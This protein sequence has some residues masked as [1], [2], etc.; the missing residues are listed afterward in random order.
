MAIFGC[1]RVKPVPPEPT[2][3]DSALQVPISSLMIPIRYHVDSLEEI[4]NSKIAGTFLKQWI[5]VNENHDSLYLELTKKSKINIRW[6]NNILHYRF[7]LYLEGKFIKHIGKNISLK[8]ETPVA[9]EVVLDMTTALSFANDWSLN[10]TTEL[11]QVTWKK[12]P[13]LKIAF[14]NINLRKRLDKFLQ[15]NT[16]LLTSIVDRE[17]DKVIDTR[18]IL[19]KLWL[20][21]QKPIIL[22]NKTRIVWLKHRAQDLAANLLQ[23]G[24]YLG[25]DVRLQTFVKVGIDSTDMPESNRTLPAYERLNSAEDSIEIFLKASASF[26]TINEIL[27]EA[28]QGKIISS[29]NYSTTIKEVST[30]ATNDGLAVMLTVKGDADGSLY[31]R[32]RPGY[33]TTTQTLTIKDFEFDVDSENA[34]LQSADWLLHEDALKFVEAELKLDLSPLLAALPDVIKNAT[35]KGKSANK[36]ELFLTSLV[37]KPEQLLLTK[38]DFQLILKAKG[39]AVIGLQKEVFAK[40]QQKTR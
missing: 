20:D 35:E 4:I 17:I 34:L 9:L 10:A 19:E 38:N 8:N 14:V 7:P 29:N 25:L 22:N 11:K 2:T 33:D 36:L 1:E 26:E 27:N 16:S 31:M 5:E 32:G 23:D 39:K 18:T 3:L 12:E 13:V 28:L 24:Q 21:I 6:I 37:I 40:R 15:E 30:Y